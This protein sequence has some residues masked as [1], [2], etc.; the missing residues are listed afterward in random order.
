MVPMVCCTLGSIRGWVGPVLLG[1]E[2][3]HR[4]QRQILPGRRGPLAAQAG[5]RIQQCWSDP[6]QQIALHL[7]LPAN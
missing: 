1:L 6:H 4:T 3:D 7:L 5:W 2:L